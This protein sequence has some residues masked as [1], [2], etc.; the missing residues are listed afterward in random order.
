MGF[1]TPKSIVTHRKVSSVCGRVEH[2]WVP[3]DVDVDGKEKAEEMHRMSGNQ[4]FSDEK[5]A[6]SVWPNK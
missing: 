5:R 6:F 1:E 2:I 3:A 4:T